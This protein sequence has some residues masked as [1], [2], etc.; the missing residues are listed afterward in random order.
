MTLVMREAAT[1]V[2][3]A[4]QAALSLS[5]RLSAARHDHVLLERG[6]VGDAWLHR[7][8]SLHLL[9]PNW[10]NRLDGGPAHAAEH[11]FLKA[12]D[13]AE[14]LRSY[15]RSFHAPV[16]ERTAVER[17]ARYGD[18]YVIE[19]DRG[20][21]RA[22]SVVI[23]TGHAATPRIPAVSAAAPLGL[24]Q[25]HSSA[26][27][28]P[29]AL[30]A[31]GVLVVGAGPSGQQIA[32]ELRRA[33]R[34]VV[35][36]VGAHARGMRRYRGRDIWHWLREI[37]DLDRTRE[38]LGPDFTGRTTSLTLSGTNGGEQLD[39]AALDRL[40]IVV[41]GRLVGFDGAR[42]TFAEDLETTTA[43]ADL[44]MRGTLDRIDEHLAA[45][46]PDW[47]HRVRR[48][49]DVRL[50]SGP[51]SV[52]LPAAGISTVIWAT[53]YR[54]DY[55]WLDVPAAVGDAGEIVQRHGVADVPG[56]YTIGLNFQ[57]YR[58]SHLIGGVGADAVLLAQQ[59]VVAGRQAPARCTAAARW[60]QLAY[61]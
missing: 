43:E 7:W 47:P 32:A 2:I 57:R 24:R 36:A 40:G 41:A 51:A 33:G 38:D 17:V 53:G 55:S 21:W 4:G 12:S 31:G 28:N 44:A 29:S 61:T 30:P 60:A 56:L 18:G 10:L 13:F 19:T 3:G 1:I 54:R 11:G 42:A 8:D 39:L 27:R 35:I 58:G 9:T 52:D 45:L 14:Y 49:R 59:I 15:A 50:G 37:G 5:R 20:P 26:Y 23:A 6:R 34:H 25:L 16:Q 46:E 48:L 22:G